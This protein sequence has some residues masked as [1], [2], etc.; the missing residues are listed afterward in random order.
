VRAALLLATT[1]FAL[2]L[3]LAFLVAALALPFGRTSDFIFALAIAV[4]S[5]SIIS[6][7][8]MQYE[9]QEKE[10]GQIILA[11]VVV[12]DLLAFVLL[13]AASSPLP[14]TLAVVAETGIFIVAFV[15]VDLLLNKRPQAFR[16]ALTRIGRMSRREDLAYAS[17]IVVGLAVA[18]VFQVIGLSYIIGAYF[19]GL[20][21]HDG[22][23]GR[24]A[25][26]EVSQTLAR[27]NRAIF[28]PFFF[29]FA[30]LEANLSQS[31]YG[32]LAGLVLVLAASIIPAMAV[33]FL[34]TR[35]ALRA[36]D[37]EGPRQIAVTLGGRGAVGIVI[38]SV[39]LSNGIFDNVAYS[40]TVIG[41]LGISLVVPVLLGRKGVAD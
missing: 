35:L 13:A 31:S 12:A 18:S 29:G 9:M 23:I 38:A 16:R 33:T 21:V 8:V 10:S 11:T 14:S 15:L 2:P 26:K 40:L 5:I 41:T 24:T 37:P 7:L 19:A 32:L 6:V 34:V 30:G 20:I 1:S 22:L 17:L 36:K 3:A 4:P 28:I 27:M 25:F 39:A